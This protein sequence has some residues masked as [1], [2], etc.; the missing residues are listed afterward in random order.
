VCVCECGQILHLPIW[1]M[2]MCSEGSATM[3]GAV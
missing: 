2:S 3:T 1:V